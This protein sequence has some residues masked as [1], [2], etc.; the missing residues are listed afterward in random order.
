MHHDPR[1]PSP[2]PNEARGP[3]SRTTSRDFQGRPDFQRPYPY[4]ERD[5]R[6]LRDPRDP[7]DPRF[8]EPHP[9]ERGGPPG[10]NRNGRR[11]S[12]ARE[13]LG[14]MR[15]PSPAASTSSK[16]SR[17]AVKK[18][19]PRRVSM[20]KRTDPSPRQS[21]AP[22]RRTIDEDYD[23]GAADALMF[24]HSDRRQPPPEQSPPV[25]AGTKR[26]S[27]P[28]PELSRPVD[29]KKSRGS[30][31]ANSPTKRQTVIEVLNAPRATPTPRIEVL[32]KPHD[33]PLSP[34]PRSPEIHVRA[35]SKPPTPSD[36]DKQNPTTPLGLTSAP[37]SDARTS[38]VASRSSAARS[39]EVMPRLSKSP[40]HEKKSPP[41]TG[42]APAQSPKISSARDKEGDVEM[43]ESQ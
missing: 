38:P 5:P 17:R 31:F 16:A 22:S 11:P 25:V 32:N 10:W 1:G 13:Q 6:D 19:D 41:T 40:D 34:R 30:P 36:K 8:Y 39:P 24:L 28:S 7:R 2:L 43:E 3:I 35:A 14:D 9:D 37:T 42:S 18:E 23:E 4:D 12:I 26:P 21:P 33:K 27:P 20:P 15:A 29:S